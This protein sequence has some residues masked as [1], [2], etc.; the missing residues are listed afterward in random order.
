MKQ[1]LTNITTVNMAGVKGEYLLKGEE[2]RIKIFKN[3]SGCWK[4]R[5][6]TDRKYDIQGNNGK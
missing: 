4:N 1:A 3:K 5:E 6:C 2:K